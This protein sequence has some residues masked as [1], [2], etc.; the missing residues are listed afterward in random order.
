MSIIVTENKNAVQ[1]LSDIRFEKTLYD[2]DLNKIFI[3]QPFV[4]TQCNSLDFY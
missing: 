2:V 3:F 4:T 1:F